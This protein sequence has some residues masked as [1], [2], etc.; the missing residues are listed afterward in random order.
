MLA[1]S[2][3]VLRVWSSPLAVIASFDLTVDISREGLLIHSQREITQGL[4]GV[5]NLQCGPQGDRVRRLRWPGELT[6]EESEETGTLSQGHSR[7]W[8]H[9]DTCAESLNYKY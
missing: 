4:N 2:A 6:R 8:P 3:R 9:K 5:I 1:V 7:P